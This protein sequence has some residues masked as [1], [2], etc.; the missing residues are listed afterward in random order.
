MKTENMKPIAI[1]AR[2]KA[3]NNLLRMARNRAIALESADGHR[4]ALTLVDNWEGFDVGTDKDFAK[5][6]ERTARNKPLMKLL[7]SRKK[8]AVGKRVALDEVKKQLGID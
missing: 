1:S 6:V 8:N 5:E 7:A 2:N 3:P 4:Y